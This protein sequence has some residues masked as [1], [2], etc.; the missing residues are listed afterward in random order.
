MEFK[1]L[2]FVVILSN[3]NVQAADDQQRQERSLEDQHLLPYPFHP[4]L[5]RYLPDP[6]AQGVCYEVISNA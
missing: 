5:V 4:K 3:A 6:K 1:K 2:L